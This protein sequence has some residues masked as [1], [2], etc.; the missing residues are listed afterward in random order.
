[1]VSRIEADDEIKGL[2]NSVPLGTILPWVNKPDKECPHQEDLPSGYAL[3]DGSEIQEG[4]WKGRPTPDLSNTAK[5]L[6][7]GTMS[8]VLDLEDAMLKD[9]VHNDPGHNHTDDG[10]THTDS[11]HSHSYHDNY[12]DG[13]GNTCDG[14]Y[15]TQKSHSKTSGTSHAQISTSHAV[16]NTEYTG[17]G[18]VN[19][20]NLTI[21]SGDSLHPTNMKVLYIMRVA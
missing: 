16:I 6:R 15:W 5:F 1:M 7:G 12:L 3:C 10:H 11:G 20:T 9:H 4:I 8:Q 17:I 19:E 14:R 18:G 13:D 2:L 21:D